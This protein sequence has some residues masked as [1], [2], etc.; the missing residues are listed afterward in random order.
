MG[1]PG[2]TYQDG[3]QTIK[4]AKKLDPD[5]AKFYY[6]SPYGE[7]RK[8]VSKYGV[9]LSNNETNFTGNTIIFIPYSMTKQE[10]RKL[11]T[12]AYLEFYLRPKMF[13]R[14][15]KKPLILMN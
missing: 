13:L 6:L 5:Y 4:L 8:K 3:I 11:Y 7:L 12:L 15:I 9:F 1:I 10:L 2:E 14:R